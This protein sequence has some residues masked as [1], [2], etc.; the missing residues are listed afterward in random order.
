MSMGERKALLFGILGLVA[1]VAPL[2]ATDRDY[3][4]IDALKN[5]DVAS[6]RALLRAHIDVNAARADGSTALHWAAQWNELEVAESL[7]KAG[8]NVN[9]Q[10]DLGVAPM[11]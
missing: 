2:S 5:R 11:T 1:V 6:A 8:A 9:A 3:R 7:I 4:L 10:T